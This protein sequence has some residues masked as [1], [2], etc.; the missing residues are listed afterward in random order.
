MLRT[1]TQWFDTYRLRQQGGAVH[2][3][4]DRPMITCTDSQGEAPTARA[5]LPDICG[6]RYGN[7]H[8]RSQLVG[9]VGFGTRLKRL[10]GQEAAL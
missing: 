7:R 9:V 6:G 4:R 10:I 8:G 2:A 1:D 5:R 3:P